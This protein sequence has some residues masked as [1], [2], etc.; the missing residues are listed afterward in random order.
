MKTI[1]GI[2]T[3]AFL[4]A[5]SVQA[6][7]Q[8][9]VQKKTTT[10]TVRVTDDSQITTKTIEDTDEEIDVIEVK[11]TDDLNQ[12]ASVVK[13]NADTSKLV[14]DTNTENSENKK[15]VATKKEVQLMELEASKKAMELQAQK[16]KLLLEQKKKAMMEELAKRRAA[17]MKRPKGMAKLQKDPDGDV[18]N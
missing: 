15:M 3:L 8:K 11:G 4:I 1:L 2:L 7:T 12:K 18:I 14:G 10:K 16:E 5:G 13:K 6:Q 17:L 9:D